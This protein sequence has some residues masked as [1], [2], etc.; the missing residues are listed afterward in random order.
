MLEPTKTKF[1]K[2]TDKDAFAFKGQYLDITTLFDAVL[3]NGFNLNIPQT[4]SITNNILTIV[5]DSAHGFENYSVIKIENA[6]VEIVN[7][8]TFAYT[9]TGQ[10]TFNNV[11][12]YKHPS[13]TAVQLL[14]P[15]AQTVL[16]TTM[17]NDDG[18]FVLRYNTYPKYSQ[19]IAI[20][21]SGEY[22]TQSLLLKTTS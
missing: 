18:S 6:D 17:T 22:N 3:V 13:T 4:F 15:I 21:Y 5:F 7:P 11:I 2:Y 8:K 12:K 1:F 9:Y 16:K 19:L 10:V 14:D 20:D